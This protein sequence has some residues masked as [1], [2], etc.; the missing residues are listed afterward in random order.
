MFQGHRYVRNV[1]CKLYLSSVVQTVYG[2][3]IH[4]KDYAHYDLLDSVVYSREI[5]NMFLVGQVSGLVRNL[6]LEIYLD[7]I[8]VI[9]VKNLLNG[10]THWALSAHTSFTDL[11]HISRSQQCWT[12]L[13]ENFVFFTFTDIQGRKLMCFRTWQKLTLWLF[14]RHCL[15][16][17]FQTLCDYNL[18]WGLAV[19]TR[20]DDLNLILRSQECQ[21]CRSYFRFLSTVV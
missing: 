2:W 5:M 14:G 12:V 11:G 13:I 16:E 7:T 4:L 9:N 3:C 21:N 1:N 8:Y 17:V 10:T 18:A 6:K 15:R 19:Y 20:F